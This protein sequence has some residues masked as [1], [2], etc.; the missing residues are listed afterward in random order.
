MTQTIAIIGGGMAGLS[1]AFYIQKWSEEKQL[2]V[3]PLVIE[4][5]DHLGGKFDTLHRDGFVIER[6][7]DS[8]LKRKTAAIDLAHD[9][10]LAEQLVDNRTGK[11][12]ILYQGHL[13]LIPTGSVMGVPGDFVPLLETNLL[14]NEGKARVFEEL[15]LPPM[16]PFDDQSVGDFFEQRVGR[17]LVERVIGP[18]L[19][20]VYGG[21]LYHLSLESTLPQ[22]KQMAMQHKSLLQAVHG[23]ASGKKTSQFATLRD[24]LSTFCTQ[25][26]ERLTNKPVIDTAI[27]SIQSVDD[28]FVLN[29]DGCRF[30][31]DAVILA[32]PLDAAQKLLPDFT[33]LQAQ[34][35][36]DDSGMTTISLA[37][38]QAAVQ[39]ANEG[40]GFVASD[41]GAGRL[42]AAT[43]THLKWPHTTPQGKALLR[44]F[45]GHYADWD[46]QQES[47]QALTDKACRDLNAIEGITLSGAPDFS[48]ITHMPHS[49]PQY[50][51]GHNRWLCAL[52]KE[53]VQRF[54]RIHL[55]GMAYDGVGI[56]DVIRQGKQAAEAAVE[57]L[58]AT[59]I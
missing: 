14:S 57:S 25:I 3:L 8:F 56:P 7:P 21:D 33:A 9:L 44:V 13:H 6:G 48:V 47:D 45:Y 29:G 46:P 38:D 35:A 22:F 18:L 40:T 37:F 54:S 30:E 1:A 11:A 50:A 27:E 12:Y 4:A 15:L 24:G 17:E 34:S 32:T 16:T 19:S 51:V 31:A 42:S 58:S 23:L 59:I 39:L 49:M 52:E 28:R 2:D 43:W 5:T 26:A 53:R 36:G 10:G 55:A 41:R 20:G